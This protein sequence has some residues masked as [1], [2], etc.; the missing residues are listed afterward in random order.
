MTSE[1]KNMKQEKARNW[2][3]KRG[4]SPECGNWRGTEYVIAIMSEGSVAT[5]ADI[6]R[7]KHFTRERAEQVLE[8]IMAYYHPAPV[9]MI[10]RDPSTQEEASAKGE[11]K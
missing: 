9:F 10:E 8:R 3:I 2:V 5:T 4:N 11:S 6:T 1:S 7:A